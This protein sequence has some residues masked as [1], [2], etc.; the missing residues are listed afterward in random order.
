MICYGP[1]FKLGVV[2]VLESGTVILS[3]AD[4]RGCFLG[5][6]GWFHSDEREVVCDAFCYDSPVIL[7]DGVGVPVV[8]GVVWV[9][10]AV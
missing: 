10:Q 7:E 8:Q 9:G 5:L 3:L 1:S 2:E 6:S 4:C